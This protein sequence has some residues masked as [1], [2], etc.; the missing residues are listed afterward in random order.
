MRGQGITADAVIRGYFSQIFY[1]KKRLRHQICILEQ[2]NNFSILKSIFSIQ[3]LDV[4]NLFLVL[5][6]CS[7]KFLWQ[8]WKYFPEPHGHN[9]LL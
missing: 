2:S 3:A 1:N 8:L 9:I 4:I 6:N 5:Y 7:V